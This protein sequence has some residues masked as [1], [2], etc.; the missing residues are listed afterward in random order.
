MHEAGELFS[1]GSSIKGL[2]PQRGGAVGGVEVNTDKN[3]VPV[4]I[5]FRGSLGKS[6]KLVAGSRHDGFETGFLKGPFQSARN[7]EIEV[8]L[9]DVGVGSAQVSSSVTGIDDHGFKGLRRTDSEER[10]GKNKGEEKTG[11]VQLHEECVE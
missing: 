3:G 2:D 6:E 11:A 7:I 4:S 9:V 10:S 8:L 5:R 1:I